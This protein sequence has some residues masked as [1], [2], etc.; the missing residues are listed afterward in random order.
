MG[1]YAPTPLPFATSLA[2]WCIKLVKDHFYIKGEGIVLPG[3]VVI[4]EDEYTKA[5][6]NLDTRVKLCPEMVPPYD[7]EIA[8][9]V[10]VQVQGDYL[11]IKS[12]FR[13]LIPA[14]GI[15]Y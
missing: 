2:L 11:P 6:V 3:R 7:L 12:Y 8:C 14:G 13:Q 9:I 10:S 15:Q 5:M 4:L 1:V